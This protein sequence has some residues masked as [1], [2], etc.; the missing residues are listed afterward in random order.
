MSIR[1]GVCQAI[2]HYAQAN[3]KYMGVQ[4]NKKEESSYIEYL[5]ANNLYGCSMSRKLP[6]G[7]FKWVEDINSINVLG[8]NDDDVGYV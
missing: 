6:T 3:N 5:D 7:G 8:Y 4:H 2:M 1:G